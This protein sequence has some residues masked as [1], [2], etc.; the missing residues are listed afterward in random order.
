[1]PR[2]QQPYI[3]S[4]V[5]GLLITM[6]K[7]CFNASTGM[8][9]DNFERTSAKVLH[10]A[11]VL[12]S[13]FV[14]VIL[15][16]LLRAIHEEKITKKWMNTRERERDSKQNLFVCVRQQEAPLLSLIMRTMMNPK[17]MGWRDGHPLMTNT[18]TRSNTLT[19]ITTKITPVI[20]NQTGLI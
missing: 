12:E 18:H 14:Y 16:N 4:I 10:T 19:T 9:L 11:I 1:M 8:F 13:L 20:I 5:A 2:K 7:R 3:I 15:C 6:R 17:Q